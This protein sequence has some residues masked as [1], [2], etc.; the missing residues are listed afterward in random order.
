MAAVTTREA[1]AGGS[2]AWLIGLDGVFPARSFHAG[3]VN[4]VMA[5]ASVLFLSNSIDLA[6]YQRLGGRNDGESVAMP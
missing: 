1:H 2:G 4:A 6:T 5:D 3:G